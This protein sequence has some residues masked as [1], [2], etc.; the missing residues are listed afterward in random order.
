MEDRVVRAFPVRG[1]PA[2]SMFGVCD[3]HGGSYAAR[4]LASHLPDLLADEAA[5]S[6]HRLLGHGHGGQ[7]QDE[8]TNPGIIEQILT[9][10]CVGADMSLAHEPRMLVERKADGTVDCKDSSGST[11]VMCLITKNYV[12]IANVGDSRAVL[13][14]KEGANT[15]ATAY[16]SASSASVVGGG[17]SSNMHSDGSSHHP[18]IPH[19]LPGAPV[20][21]PFGLSREFIHASPDHG[22]SADMGSRSQGGVHLSQALMIPHLEAVALSTDHKFSIPAERARAEAAGAM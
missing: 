12:A 8:D 22:I 18:S 21:D 17:G 19:G 5:A 11:L 15:G 1:R 3:G 7:S 10:V 16:A 13:A 4:Y 2:W 14:L 9:S 20:T 6:A